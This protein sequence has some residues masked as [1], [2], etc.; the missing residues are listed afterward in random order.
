MHYDTINCI[1]ILTNTIFTTGSDDT[2]TNVIRLMFFI[3]LLVLGHKD[4]KVIE[5]NLISR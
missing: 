2:Y 5:V 1:D 4:G 3:V